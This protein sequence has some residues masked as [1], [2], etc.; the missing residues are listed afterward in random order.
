[1]TRIAAAL[2]LILVGATAATAQE[3]RIAAV[4]NDDMI[5]LGDLD[6]RVR[7]VL[8]SSQLPDNEQVRQRATPQVLRTLIDEKLEMQEAKKLNVTASDD[9]I[10]KTLERLEQQ[11]NLPKGGLEK[12]LS[13]NNIPRSTLIDQITSSLMWNKLVEQK[14]GPSVSISDEEVKD[15]LARIKQEVG[16][17]QYR[18]A[19]IYLAIDNPSQ[20][21]DVKALADRLIDQMHPVADPTR[22]GGVREGANFGAVAQQFSQ[23]PTAAVGGDL[24]WLTTAELP[25]DIAAV[26]QGMQPGQLSAPIRTAGGF[27]IVG[28][29]DRRTFGAP[30]PD[31]ML[32]TIAKIIFPFNPQTAT[33]ADKQKA[34]LAAQQ[35]SETA[36]SCDDMKRIGQER[37]PQTSGEA[38]DVK[39]GGLN[40]DFRKLLDSMQI[41]QASKPI[42]IGN[43]AAVFMLCGRKEPPSQIPTR[44]QLVD[45][46]TRQRLDT[47]AR[48]YLRDLRRAAYVD[49]RV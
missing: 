27:Y 44:D 4:V 38:S 36:K 46:L 13:Q 11:N 6:A 26:V 37:A 25:R 34:F 28:L 8:L 35:V 15:T 30:G 40:P 14:L 45:T 31:E 12:M 10:N 33:D 32:V 3:T 24:G 47:L 21:A 20:E 2:V 16:K 29:V 49:M 43:G 22:P 19:E 1:M 9:E 42:N 48:R 18:V 23:S 7:L 17:P 41:G 39:I 5:S